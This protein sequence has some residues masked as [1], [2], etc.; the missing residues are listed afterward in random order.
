MMS[1]LFCYIY[2][3]LSIIGT[4]RIIKTSLS[5]DSW[6]IFAPIL[7][8]DLIRVSSTTCCS[9]QSN[10]SCIRSRIL[11]GYISRVC[12]SSW[13]SI[14]QHCTTTTTAN[15]FDSLLHLRQQENVI[16]P[17]ALKAGSVLLTRLTQFRNR[18]LSEM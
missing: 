1:I 8:R 18:S 10:E 17:S 3:L 2:L 13:L 9:Q 7:N 6:Q 4:L 15:V 12:P 16:S 11:F 5:A 14:H